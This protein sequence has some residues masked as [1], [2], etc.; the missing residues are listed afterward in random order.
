MIPKFSFF[1]TS[2]VSFL[3]EIITGNTV[4]Q[5]MSLIPSSQ[6]YLGLTYCPLISFQTYWVLVSSMIGSHENN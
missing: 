4:I 1:L 2:L 3:P 6:Q 5:I